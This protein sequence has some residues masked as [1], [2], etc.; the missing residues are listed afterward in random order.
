[1][2]GGL[3]RSLARSPG[4]TADNRSFSPAVVAAVWL[5]GRVVP[6]YDPA[7]VRKDCCGAWMQFDAYGDTNSQYGWEVDHQQPVAHGG[8]DNL[9]NLQP[10]YW[11]NNRHKADNWPQW[12]CAVGA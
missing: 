3:L 7:H 4:S 9:A 6:G 1:M 11:R 8:A 12:T 2:S 10:L 5:K